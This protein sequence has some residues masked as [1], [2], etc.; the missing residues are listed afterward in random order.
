M[1]ASR[2][3]TNSAQQRRAPVHRPGCSSFFSETV[4][5]EITAVS[6]FYDPLH[7]HPRRASDNT[8]TAACLLG[9]LFTGLR[10]KAEL[11]SAVW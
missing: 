9:S 1:H 3:V 11:T 6:R 2:P 4:S 8:P 7:E 5:H 10:G